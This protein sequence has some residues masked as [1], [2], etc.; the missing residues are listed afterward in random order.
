MQAFYKYFCFSQTALF[1]DVPFC[2]T[3]LRS[4][5]IVF[6]KL[7]D[8]NRVLLQ[9]LTECLKITCERV[10]FYKP[11]SAKVKLLHRFF[12]KVLLIV[13]ELLKHF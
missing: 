9:I 4:N 6:Y 8:N 13:A 3:T 5:S 11:R 7:G 10:N 2:K 12:P 1:V